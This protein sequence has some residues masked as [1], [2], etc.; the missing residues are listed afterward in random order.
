VTLCRSIAAGRITCRHVA[1]IRD[2]IH[3]VSHWRPPTRSTSSTR[4]INV[5]FREFLQRLDAEVLA[6]LRT[7][8]ITPDG[9]DLQA[10]ACSALVHLTYMINDNP[11]GNILQ[12]PDARPETARDRRPSRS[13]R[14]RNVVGQAVPDAIRVRFFRRVP[15]IRRPIR[16]SSA[17]CHSKAMTG[18]ERCALALGTPLSS[19]STWRQA[20]P[21]L[22]ILNAGAPRVENRLLRLPYNAFPS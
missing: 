19:A 1:E 2:G 7:V 20:Q 9:V 13:G 10:E 3:L 18:D 16:D 22:R 5:A 12:T 8:R 11:M 14:R 6:T 17:V 15:A 21:D 4:Q